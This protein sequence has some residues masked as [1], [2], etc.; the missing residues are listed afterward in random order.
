MYKV[1][2]EQGSAQRRGSRLGGFAAMIAAI[3][4]L[5][6]SGSID[7]RC[8][9]T[10]AKGVLPRAVIARCKAKVVGQRKQALGYQEKRICFTL[11]HTYLAAAFMH[12][13][14]HVR[15]GLTADVARPILPNCTCIFD[16]CLPLWP[17]DSSCPSFA[18]WPDAD[19]R[20][21]HAQ[22]RAVMLAREYSYSTLYMCVWLAISE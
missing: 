1:W 4:C 22:S 12:E 16:V 9:Q 13:D 11:E 20:A 3:G 21:Y 18:C 14:A 10:R 6:E 7:V 2:C 8:I 5:R 15:S 17:L 19:V